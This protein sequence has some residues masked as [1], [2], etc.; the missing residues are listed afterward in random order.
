[1]KLFFQDKVSYFLWGTTYQKCLLHHY[2][3][4]LPCSAHHTQKTLKASRLKEQFEVKQ[5]AAGEDWNT[6]I[7]HNYCTADG[8]GLLHI[9]CIQIYIIAMY[10]CCIHTYMHTHFVHDFVLVDGQPQISNSVPRYGNFW[11]YFQGENMSLMTQMK[12][13]NGSKSF[14]LFFRLFFFLKLRCGSVF[15]RSIEADRELSKHLLH[16]PFLQLNK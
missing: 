10:T 16:L 12:T 5:Q 11:N 7:L 14:L 13:D 15:H 6:N 4:L 1:M 3:T 8:S 9:A 2:F